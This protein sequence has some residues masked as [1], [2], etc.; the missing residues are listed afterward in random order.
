MKKLALVTVLSVV[1]AVA[2]YAHDA[3]ANWAERCVKCHGTDGRGDTKMGKKLE[4]KDYTDAK[5]QAGF[6][7]E[8]AIKALK[9]GVKDRV[10]SARMKPVEGLSEAEI[11]ALV[12]YVRSLKK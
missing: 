5:V 4:V 9:E 7:D 3:K 10:G 8:V 1:P 11:K 12:A 6:T 2:G